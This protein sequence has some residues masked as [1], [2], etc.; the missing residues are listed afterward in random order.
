MRINGISN[1][2]AIKTVKKKKEDNTYSEI[3]CIENDDYNTQ[4]VT[5]VE[6]VPCLENNLHQNNNLAISEEQLHKML[7]SLQ[8][9]LEY[10]QQSIL[11][12]D[13]TETLLSEI[14]QLTQFMQNNQSSTFALQNII[15]EIVTRCLIEIELI[16]NAK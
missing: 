2:T 14:L 11:K 8:N 10:L 1:I 4:S 13:N 3:F 6:T 15:N 5:E 9:K 7:Y 16:K 12:D